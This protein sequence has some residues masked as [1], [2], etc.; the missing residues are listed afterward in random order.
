MRTWPADAAASTLDM[1]C[2]DRAWSAL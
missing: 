1:R 2:P